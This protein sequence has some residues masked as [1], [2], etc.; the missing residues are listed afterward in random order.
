MLLP[1]TGQTAGATAAFCRTMSNRWLRVLP[2]PFVAFLNGWVALSY[3]L[4]VGV[5]F[6]S[7]VV[8]VVVGVVVVGVVVVAALVLVC[9]PGKRIGL[10]FTVPAA[11]T[12]ES[13][14]GGGSGSVLLVWWCCCRATDSGGFAK[15]EHFF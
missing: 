8:V 15:A 9:G 14:K 10:R 11:T 3:T 5:S 4:G 7:F 6:S 1:K 12:S 13:T 2:L